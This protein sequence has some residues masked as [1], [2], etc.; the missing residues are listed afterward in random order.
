MVLG[1]VSLILFAFLRGMD[2][3]SHLI[4]YRTFD[5]L[6]PAFAV[7]VGLGFAAL[8]KGRRSL[9]IALSLSFVVVTASTLPIA[10]SAKELF[11]VENQTY[12]FEYDAFEW[13]SGHGTG[14]ITSDQRLSDTAWR[15]FDVEGWRGMPYDLREGIAL[16]EG[17]FYALELDWS[18]TG[19]Q[20]FPFGTVVVPDE[21]ISSAIGPSDVVYV[22][23]P[24]GGQLV[25]LRR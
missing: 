12:W 4:I 16:E 24:L 10:Y 18:S 25:V 6:M 7:F 23:G 3:T 11:G 1:P 21:K 9:G 17:R 20:E 22:A 14:K 13:W 8:V 15:L 19:A 2:A 5:F